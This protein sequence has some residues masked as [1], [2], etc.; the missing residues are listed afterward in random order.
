MILGAIG[1]WAV[2][3]AFLFYVGWAHTS[4]SPLVLSL[5]VVTIVVSLIALTTHAVGQRR[6]IV[7]ILLA[8][9]AAFVGYYVA[10]VMGY[11]ALLVIG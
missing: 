2:A 7:A 3:M 1:E 9:S 4:E 10:A 5:F 8:S 11:I 6:P